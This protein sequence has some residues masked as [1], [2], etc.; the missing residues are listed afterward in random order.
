MQYTQN[1][2]TTQIQKTGIPGVDLLKNGSLRLLME[3]NI[4][5]KIERR[6]KRARPS[7][8]SLVPIFLENHIR[9]KG[10][11]RKSEAHHCIA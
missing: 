1:H 10:K 5:S 4:V 3:L 11:K 6:K 2:T 9:K 7:Q 8:S